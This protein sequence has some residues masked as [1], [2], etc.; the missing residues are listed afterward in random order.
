MYT[1]LLTNADKTKVQRFPRWILFER[2]R[3]QMNFLTEFSIVLRLPKIT[4]S[5][6]F[7]V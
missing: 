3:M 1:D 5:S 4:I 6:A 7:P 2:D